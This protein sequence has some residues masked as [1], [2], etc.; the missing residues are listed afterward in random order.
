[1]KL[2]KVAEIQTGYQIRKKLEKH[3]DSSFSLIQMSSINYEEHTINPSRTIP[4]SPEGSFERHVLRKGDLIMCLKGNHN[5]VVMIREQQNLIASNQ[6]AIIRAKENCL[7]EF[8]KWYL[9]SDL[10]T[11][12]LDSLSQGTVIKTLSAKV[13]SSMDIDL[14]SLE[15]QKN[16]INLQRIAQ[17]EIKLL[18]KLK[19]LKRMQSNILINKILESN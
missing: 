12:Q 14:P 17:K 16:I 5:S 4:F 15:S 13:L 9:L 18:L 1:M 8:L 7:P 19:D 10:F 3:H 2:S 6:F 11:K